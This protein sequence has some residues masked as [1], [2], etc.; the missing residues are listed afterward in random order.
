MEKR[1]QSKSLP[2]NPKISDLNIEIQSFYYIK[3]QGKTSIENQSNNKWS[4]F[5]VVVK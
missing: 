1:A 4:L 3:T 5:G 2:V